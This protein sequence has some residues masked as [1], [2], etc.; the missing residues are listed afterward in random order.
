[1]FKPNFILLSDAYKYSHHKLYPK[2]TTKVYSYLESRG[3]KFSETLFF[4]LQMF[5][6]K[7]LEGVVITKEDV[8]EAVEYLSTE[9]GVF[10]RDD[11]FDR[12]KFDYIV[13]V[14]G[15]K[16]P[17]KIKAVKEGTILST[18]NVLLT[19]EN[20]D[21]NCYWL[22]NF[23]ETI[24]LQIWYPITVGTLSHEVKKLVDKYFD[25]TTDFDKPT[26]DFV[27]GFVLIDFGVRGVSSIESAEIGGAAHLVN[28]MGSDNL[29]AARAVRNYYNTRKVYAKS[30]PATEHSIMTMLGEEGEL[31][32]MKRTLK[33][34]PTGIVACVSDSFNI[35]RACSDYWGG[36]LKELIL[37]RP[38]TP[39]NQLV[40]RPDSGDPIR[41]LEA[42]FKILFDKF[43]YTVNSKG[44]K[45]LPPQVRV[46][47]GDGVNLGS[48]EE[49]YKKL[50]E[51]GISAENFVFGMGGKLLQGVDRDTLNFAI[52]C[53]FAIVNGQ[54]VEVI[55]NPTEMDADG[56]IGRS[57]KVSKKG[58]L[59]L[60]KTQ[61][62]FKTVSQSEEGEDQLLDIFEDGKILKEFT[63]GEIRE[64]VK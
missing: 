24:L 63:F 23:I 46:I 57:F 37:S 33:T 52:K 3:G 12:S 51:L 28:F 19:I 8:D 1:M 54:E 60:V 26:A 13:D 21:P 50:Y 2:G 4:G 64:M 48:I 49:I 43:G 44:F 5:L 16:L 55:K 29:P 41:T 42:V 58:R 59:K 39:G 56:N 25:L 45:V 62:G 35:F 61:D 47:Q 30:V 32:M 27:K 14:L 31:E 22:T 36:E 53:S 38:A 9:D 10:G 11:V 6:K 18:K 40:I 34:F 20:T 7:Y 17:I 15:G